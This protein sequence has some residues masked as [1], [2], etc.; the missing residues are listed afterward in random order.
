MRGESFVIRPRISRGH[1]TIERVEL[2][3]SSLLPEPL[4]DSGHHLR[5]SEVSK[6]VGK[7][8]SNDDHWV[9]VV[10]FES[11]YVFRR[12]ESSQSTP[13]GSRDHLRSLDT[14]PKS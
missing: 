2:S 5:L 8:P 10:P 13:R 11:K 7:L 3:A 4:M 9:L 14:C 12:G 1:L 6:S